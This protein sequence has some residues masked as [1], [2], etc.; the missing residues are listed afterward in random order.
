MG[1]EELETERLES[2]CFRYKRTD[3]HESFVIIDT[4]SETT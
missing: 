3:G 4:D 2:E 1:V